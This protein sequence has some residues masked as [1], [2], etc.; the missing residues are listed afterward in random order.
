MFGNQYTSLPA[1]QQQQDQFTPID[2]IS[3]R[4]KMSRRQIVEQFD[5]MRAELTRQD[6]PIEEYISAVD[7]LRARAKQQE[8]QLNQEMDATAM[9]LNVIMG[10]VEEGTLPSD[11][12]Q[13]AMWRTTGLDNEAINAIAPSMRDKKATDWMSEHSKVTGEI[14]RLM[15]FTNDFATR[16]GKLYVADR[17]GNPIKSQP[18]TDEEIQQYVQAEQL[19]DYFENYEREQIYP[20]L[21][22]EQRSAMYGQSAIARQKLLKHKPSSLLG[23]A[24]RFVLGASPLVV[25]ARYATAPKKNAVKN[26][27]MGGSEVHNT[28]MGQQSAYSNAKPQIRTNPTTGQQA[29]STDGGKTWQIR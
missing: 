29:I 3:D 27:L 7:Q 9:S 23:K 5:S 25:A 15:S 13:R 21:A 19:L 10:L 28:I 6:L 1:E 8:V 11:V 12:A 18:A 2:V 16:K 26:M 14:N 4:F 22:P 20:N 17:G 24:K